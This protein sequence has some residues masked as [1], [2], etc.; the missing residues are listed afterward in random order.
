MS[1][2]VDI[3]IGDVVFQPE[4]RDLHDRSGGRIELRNKSS[5]VLACLAARAGDIV[6]KSDLME[7]AWPDTTVTDESLAQCISDIRRAIGDSDQILLQTF[8]G[9]GYCL[10]AAEDRAAKTRRWWVAPVSAL[11]VIVIAVTAYWYTRPIGRAALELA[12]PDKPSIAV[13]A[14]DDHSTGDNRDYLSDAI[15]EGIIT[16]LSRFSELFVIARNSS[17]S[18]RETAT[19]IREI[20][21]TL[22]VKYVLEGSQQKNGNSLRVTAQLIDAVEGQH[23]WSQSYDRELDNLFLVQDDIVRRVVSTVAENLIVFEGEKAKTSDISKLTSLLHHLKARL[24]F[25]EFTREGTEKA[26]QAN[27]AAIDADPMQPFGY[28][29]LTFVYING[30]RWGWGDLGREESLAEARKSAQMALELAP[31]FYESHNAMGYVHAQE[32]E[33]GRAIARFETALSLNPNS[34]AAM[35]NLAEVLGYYGRAEEAEEV[36]VRAMRLDPLHPDWMKWNLA[37]IQW[38]SGKCDEALKT[39]HTMS[40]IIPLAYRSLANIHVCLDQQPQA[41]EAIAQLVQHYPGYSIKDVRNNPNGKY[42]NRP[43]FER[44]VNGLRKAG[45]PE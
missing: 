23:L 16:D 28:V 13:L 37:W 22:G 33:L 17:F 24:Y 14:F 11:I 26:R 20:A 45:L 27:I 10:N 40:Q 19:D 35:S 9:K 21:Q 29:G 36:Q 12:L 42:K 18:I 38:M 41:E 34:T 44:Y 39:M 2:P 3:S 8:V 15:A 5:E 25:R 32:G 30:Y 1:N 31:N 43:D 6:S 7:C 4:T